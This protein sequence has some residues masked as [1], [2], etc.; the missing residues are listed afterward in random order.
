MTN[1]E[2][3]PTSWAWW[4]SKTGYS[5]NLGKGLSLVP[6][7]DKA[8]PAPST[9]DQRQR[10]SGEAWAQSL[11]PT[12][13]QALAETWGRRVFALRLLLFSILFLIEFAFLGLIVF[14][15]VSDP[16]QKLNPAGINGLGLYPLFG[17][18]AAFWVMHFYFQLHGSRIFTIINTVIMSYLYGLAVLQIENRSNNKFH[19]DF[20]ISDIFHLDWPAISTSLTN[21]HWFYTIIII[22]IGAMLRWFFYS[23]I[24]IYNDMYVPNNFSS[25]IKYRT[26]SLLKITMIS[27]VVFIT[28]SVLADISS[29]IV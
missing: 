24:S 14:S 21:V 27:V 7:E 13:R 12:E 1:W 11:T 10:A 3:T 8:K 5:M 28:A 2:V 9:P 26:I 16:Y 23:Q 25:W 4:K 17:S 22:S 20:L 15:L 6:V 19:L 18:I 29:S